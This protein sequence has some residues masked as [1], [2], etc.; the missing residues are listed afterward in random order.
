MVD[1]LSQNE[2]DA[3]LKG[4]SGGAIE[5][6]TDEAP[7]PEGVQGFDFTDQDRIIRGLMPTL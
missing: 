2:V 5:A 4:L 3:L 6:E 7:V 1:V